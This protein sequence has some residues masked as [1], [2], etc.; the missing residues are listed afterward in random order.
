MI[1]FNLNVTEAT[2]IN[3]HSLFMHIFHILVLM[4]VCD[5]FRGAINNGI[6]DSWTS[7]WREETV[8]TDGIWRDG[9][10]LRLEWYHTSRP[11]LLPF[12]R[13]YRQPT[14]QVAG[15]SYRLQLLDLNKSI[16]F[17]SRQEPFIAFIEKLERSLIF[18]W[19]RQLRRRK[20]NPFFIQEFRLV[21]IS[22]NTSNLK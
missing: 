13:I 1:F 19:H 12:C 17:Q 2:L 5:Q 16:G 7:R 20:T 14:R 22:C 10:N 18:R 21:R 11:G 15:I 8:V 3:L 6:S 4:R 9:R